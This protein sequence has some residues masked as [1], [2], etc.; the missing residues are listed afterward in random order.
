MKLTSHERRRARG[1]AVPD[2]GL[3]ELR[4]RFFERLK[5]ERQRLLDLSAV[6]A[7]G[8]MDRVD[9]LAELRTR[10]H[11]LSGT[12]SILELRGVAALGH[13]LE[14]AVE[15]MA[16]ADRALVP[17]AENSDRVV[18]ATLQ[19]LIEVIDTLGK[20]APGLRLHGRLATP[21]QARRIL[22]G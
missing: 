18:R 19:A 9:V 11:R 7:P 16:A 12:A 13:A 17:R 14:L 3:Q 22:A 2:D 1:V 6:P 20:P 8:G 21:P 15:G 4:A 5:E 10:A